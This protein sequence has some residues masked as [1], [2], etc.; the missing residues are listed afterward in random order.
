MVFEITGVRDTSFYFD[1][2]MQLLEEQEIVHKVRKISTLKEFEKI[3]L[4][5]DVIS[6]VH[7]EL[8]DNAVKFTELI[9]EAALP[10]RLGICSLISE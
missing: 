9:K 10:L 8:V 1:E 4:D 5:Q 7:R 3:M 2:E 6:R